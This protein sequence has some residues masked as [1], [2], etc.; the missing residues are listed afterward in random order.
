MQSSLARLLEI[1]FW[2]VI[3]IL[4]SLI[5]GLVRVIRPTSSTVVIEEPPPSG[6][7][8]VRFNPIEPPLP[9]PLPAVDAPPVEIESY[10]AMFQEI[11]AEYEL[12]WRLLAELAYQ[13]SRMNP[14]AVGSSN[15]MG[16]M[17]IIPAT[18]NEWAPQV[19]VSDPFDPP[20][21]ARVAAAYL[22]YLREFS[23]AYGYPE[24]HWMIVGYNWGPNNLYRLFTSQGDWNH[25]PEPQRQYTIAIL[26]AAANREDR[27]Q[28]L[29]FSNK[30]D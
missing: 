11:A 13:E 8:P 27:W 17:Q 22:A 3:I 19:G 12:D 15:D 1:G 20:S 5:I 18:W 29:D 16:L 28:N 2:V 21:N 25:V 14:V 9:T 23:Q 24:E 30:K 4:L 26:Q 10:E 7:G 6:E